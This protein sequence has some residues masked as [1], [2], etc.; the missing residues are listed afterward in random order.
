[1]KYVAIA[2][3]KEY[4]IA[5]SKP[6]SLEHAKRFEGCQMHG[7]TFDVVSEKVFNNHKP[8]LK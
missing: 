6:C 8:N 1:M 2:I 4:W 7:E 5:V 3:N